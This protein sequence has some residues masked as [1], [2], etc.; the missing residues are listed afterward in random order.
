MNTAVPASAF[1]LQSG[2][3]K[4]Y[5][6]IAPSK[7]KYFLHFCGD[8]G[9]ALWIEGPTL[10]DLKILKTGVLDGDDAMDLE[11]VRP[12][13][14]QYTLRRPKWLC[15]VDGASQTEEQNTRGREALEESQSEM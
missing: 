10:P 12:K 4:S 8:C 2:R 7:T 14:E 3:P 15:A 5:T 11:G 6:I 1:H 13:A 9:S